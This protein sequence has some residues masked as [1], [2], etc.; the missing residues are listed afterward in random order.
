MNASTVHV[1]LE[2]E[3]WRDSDGTVWGAG[4]FGDAFWQRYLAVFTRVVVVSR[5]GRG[6][7]PPHLAPSRDPRVAFVPLPFYRGAAG[8]A[9][10]GPAMW[11][12]L[13]EVARADGSCIL[14][15]PGAAGTLVGLLRGAARRPFGVELV[16]DPAEVTASLPLGWA[17]PL[18]RAAWVS[19]TRRIVR[20]AVAVSYVTSQTLQARYPAGAERPSFAISSV[21]LD[22]DDF[23]PAPRR[24]VPGA[25]PARLLFCGTLSRLYKGP[26]VLI[27]SVARSVR[28]G[29]DVEATIIGDGIHRS[30][31][32][33]LCAAEGV[34]PRIRFLGQRPRADVFRELDRSDLFVLPSRT[35]GLPR[36]MIEAMARGLPCLGSRVGGIVELLDER[37]L[38]PAGDAD[39]LAG[40]IAAWLRDPPLMAAMAQRNLDAARAFGARELEPRR[41]LFYESVRASGSAKVHPSGGARGLPAET[42]PPRT[43]DSGRPPAGQR[44]PGTGN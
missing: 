21:M 2:G 32:E 38:V 34:A 33:A 35:E 10:V 40:R 13:R 5:F 4:G 17:R 36:A 18:I 24:Y 22:D 3:F 37:A 26:D 12:L 9:S 6:A 7:P 31:L 19:S 42:R 16:G 41:T 20:D 11:R 39:A 27:R 25:A 44:L 1:V 23:A 30:R 43:S 14:R 8:F 29:L 28:Q 15:A